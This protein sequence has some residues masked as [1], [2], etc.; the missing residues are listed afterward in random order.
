MLQCANFSQYEKCDFILK[1][2]KI[3]L[4]YMIKNLVLYKTQDVDEVFYKT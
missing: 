3:T 1:N 4:I 2:M